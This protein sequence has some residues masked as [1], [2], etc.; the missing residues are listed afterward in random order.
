[1]PRPGRVIL[2]DLI[3]CGTICVDRVD[4][5]RE[6]DAGVRARRAVDRR[7]DADEAARAVEQRAARVA[8][9]DRRVGLDHVGDR[10]RPDTLLISRPKP[11]ITPVVSV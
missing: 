4:G 9:V 1:M 11:E 3:S 5:H 8:R 7:V 2:P 6:A 10:T